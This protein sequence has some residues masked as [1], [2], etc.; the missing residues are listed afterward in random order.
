MRKERSSCNGKEKIDRN[1][2]TFIISL[3]C[4]ESITHF[5]K[6]YNVFVELFKKKEY[7]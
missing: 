6:D 1:K 5:I 4:D 3:P 7:N 2:K